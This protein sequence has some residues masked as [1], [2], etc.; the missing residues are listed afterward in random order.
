M[1]RE[2]PIAKAI[3]WAR[4]AVDGNGNGSYRSRWVITVDGWEG[5]FLGSGSY[6]VCS[7]LIELDPSGIQHYGA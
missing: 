1:A 4:A 7:K 2:L 3:Y 6:A 5:G